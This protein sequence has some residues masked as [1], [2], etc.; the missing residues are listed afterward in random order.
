MLPFCGYNMADY[1]QHWFNM[2]DKLGAKAP[3][4][5]YVNWFRKSTDGKWL[6]PGFG[7]N[8]RVLKWMC[9]RLDGAAKGRKTPIGILPEKNELD[10]SGLKIS[11]RELDELMAVDTPAWKHE[12]DDIASFMGQFGSRIPQRMNAQFENMKKRLSK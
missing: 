12:L 8:A 10:L 2:G 9:E 4:I 7:D 6:W 11:D 3:K 1:W 5:F